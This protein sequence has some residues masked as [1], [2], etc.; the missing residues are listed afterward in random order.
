MQFYLQQALLVL[1]E[2]EHTFYIKINWVPGRTK[3]A[4]IRR[5][6]YDVRTRESTQFDDDMF[7]NLPSH[8]N[9][10]LSVVDVYAHFWSRAQRQSKLERETHVNSATAMIAF[11]VLMPIICHPDQRK[12]HPTMRNPNCLVEDHVQIP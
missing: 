4:L 1:Q 9:E 6:V 7:V 5:D 12:C 2:E 3:E 11:A 10:K 8:I